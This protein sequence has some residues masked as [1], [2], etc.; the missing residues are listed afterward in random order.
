MEDRQITALNEMMNAVN[1]GDAKRYARLYAQDAVITIYGGGELKGRSAIE[2]YEVELLREF[3]GTRLAFY[4]VWQKGALAV[5]HYGGQRTD[6][7]RPV[8]GT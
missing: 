5:V 8:D 1:A 6:S 3:P 2:Q 4:S 7:R